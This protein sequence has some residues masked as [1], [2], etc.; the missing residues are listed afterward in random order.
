MFLVTGDSSMPKDCEL[1]AFYC[2][3]CTCATIHHVHEIVVSDT[4]LVL[5]HSDSL[6][7]VTEL[8]RSIIKP[9]LY[10]QKR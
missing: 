1:L 6:R 8:V 7:N 4:S 3:S 2:I 9:D 5:C 10:Q